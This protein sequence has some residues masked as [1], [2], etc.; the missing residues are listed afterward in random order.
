MNWMKKILAGILAACMMLSMTACSDTSWV[1][2]YGDGEKIPSGLYIVFMM[3]GYLSISSQEDYDSSKDVMKQTI[4]G[5]SSEEWIRQEA[6]RY[7]GEFVAVDRKFDE[8]GLTLTESDENTIDTSTE[9]MW[10]YYSTLYEQNKVSQSTYRRIVENNKKRE[11]IFQKYYG[12]GGIEEVPND[13]L[14]VHFKENYANVNL[15]KI[16]LETG[17]SLTDEQ[18]EKNTELKE[19]AEGYIK[20]LNEENKTFGE[21]Y[22]SYMHYLAGTEHD[23]SDEDDYFSDDDE[24][25]R[26]IKKDS[27]SYSEKVLDAIFQDVEPDGAAKMIADDGAYYI[28]KRYDMTKDGSNFEEMRD[29]V[30]QDVKGKDFSELITEWGEAQTIASVNEASY[31]KHKPQ[32]LDFETKK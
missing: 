12:T 23:D 15:F 1:Y 16:S 32:K 2:D 22:D 29:S 6:E 18:K 28:V 8:L 5:L 7:A 9:T 11:L 30:L 14:M 3:N 19:L 13:S 4:E 25:K 20:M 31:K 21:V 26:Y 24:T 10:A 27:S 17:D